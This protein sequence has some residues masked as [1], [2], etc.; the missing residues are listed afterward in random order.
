MMM[1]SNNMRKWI[2]CMAAVIWGFSS[3][4]QAVQLRIS[5]LLKKMPD[6]IMPLLTKNNRLDMIDFCEAKM[7]AEVTNLLEGQSEMTA[8]AD[9]SLTIRMSETLR[10]D[11][12]LVPAEEE[13]DSCKQVICVVSTYQLPSTGEEDVCVDYYSVRWQPLVQPKVS[14][15]RSPR[16]TLLRQDEKLRTLKPI[17]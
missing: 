13:Y 11:L 3:E 6:S 1:N 12:Y 7:K 16:S 10:M 8:L 5:D 4:C 2:I 14:I 15:I 17:P 9:D